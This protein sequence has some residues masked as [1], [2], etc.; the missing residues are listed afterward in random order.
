MS[1][2]KLTD[3]QQAFIAEYLKCWNATKAALQAGY[4]PKSAR[5][6]GSENLSK[7][8]IADEIKARIAEMKMSGDEALVRL[9]EIARGDIEDFLTIDTDATGL[10]F[11]KAQKAGKIH[12]L[13]KI[14][15]GKTT[16]SFE[17]YDKQAALNTIAKHHGLLNDKVEID[18]KL[19]GQAVEALEALGQDPA[20]VFNEIINRAKM[21][22]D[23]GH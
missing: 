9:A 7:P 18:I 12:L 11:V 8:Y 3:K 19:V 13:K 6:T 17:M 23:A 1:K 5:Q 15:F 2:T 4:S 21:K 14:T 20:A 10:D 16:I 22:Q